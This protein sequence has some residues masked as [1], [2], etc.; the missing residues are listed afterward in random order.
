LNAK[1]LGMSITKLGREMGLKVS[2]HSFRRVSST[3]THAAGVDLDTASRRLGHNHRV[4]LRD[5]VLGP[6]TAPWRG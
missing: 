3:Q 2:T 4:M 5:Y 6:M 1:A